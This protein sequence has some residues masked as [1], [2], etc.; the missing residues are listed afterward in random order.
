MRHA[1]HAYSVPMT[2]KHFLIS[3]FQHICIPRSHI[4]MPARAVHTYVRRS[5]NLFRGR[6][7]RPQE[8][9]G[10][11][12]L[13]RGALPTGA[14]RSPRMLCAKSPGLAF[15]SMQLQNAGEF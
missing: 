3:S 10:L 7:T 11:A 4:Y 1:G 14:T 9:A 12:C 8:I 15:C 2:I 6:P 13:T 5:A